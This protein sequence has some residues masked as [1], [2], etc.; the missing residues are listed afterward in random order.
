M[1]STKDSFVEFRAHTL[2]GR[3]ECAVNAELQHVQN[4]P[5][6]LV[7]VMSAKPMLAGNDNA[8]LE[9][10]AT[11]CGITVDDLTRQFRIMYFAATRDRAANDGRALSYAIACNS[12][13]QRREPRARSVA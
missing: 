10:V 3:A 9:D 11:A 7:I 1:L 4:D 8:S 13:R 6:Q 2:D 5:R 12:P